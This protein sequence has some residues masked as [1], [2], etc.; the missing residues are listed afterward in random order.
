MAQVRAPEIVVDGR[1]SALRI[2]PRG[3]DAI[4]DVG[5]IH[6]TEVDAVASVRRGVGHGGVKLGCRKQETC[7]NFTV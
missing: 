2:G 5:Q 4:Y 6:G 3:I 1:A 7:A